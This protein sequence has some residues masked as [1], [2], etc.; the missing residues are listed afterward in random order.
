VIKTRRLRLTKVFYY[1]I[2]L[3]D[4]YKGILYTTCISSWKIIAL[5]SLYLPV[6]LVVLKLI[7][8][9]G[10]GVGVV[11]SSSFLRGLPFRFPLRI[12]KLAAVILSLLACEYTSIV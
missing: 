4:N 5:D 9:K 6:Y 3:T 8:P 11:V 7:V 1:L 2:D 10:L 12:L